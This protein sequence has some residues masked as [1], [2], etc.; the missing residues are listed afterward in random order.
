[1][2]LDKTLISPSR[3]RTITNT[4]HNRNHDSDNLRKMALIGAHVHGQH[5]HIETRIISNPSSLSDTAHNLRSSTPRSSNTYGQATQ[6]QQ[7]TDTLHSRI[8]SDSDSYS[9]NVSTDVSMD[10]GNYWSHDMKMEQIQNP[11][12][13]V[14]WKSPQAG[15]PALPVHKTSI[16]K[17]ALS[18]HSLHTYDQQAGFTEIGVSGSATSIQSPPLSSSQAQAPSPR[19]FGWQPRSTEDLNLITQLPSRDQPTRTV[20]PLI[21]PSLTPNELYQLQPSTTA[22]QPSGLGESTSIPICIQTPVPV[23]SILVGS[24]QTD[25]RNGSGSSRHV[26]LSSST[27]GTSSS[28]S[29]VNSAELAQPISQVQSSQSQLAPKASRAHLKPRTTQ[30]VLRPRFRRRNAQLGVDITT[31]GSKSSVQDGNCPEAD[32]RAQRK[33]LTDKVSSLATPAHLTPIPPNPHQFRYFLPAGQDQQQ[34]QYCQSQ[35][36]LDPGCPREPTVAGHQQSPLGPQQPDTFQVPQVAG[37]KRKATQNL[38]EDEDFGSGCGSGRETAI[39]FFTSQG[40]SVASPISISSRSASPEI[41]TSIEVSEKNFPLF[42][43]PS[44]PSTSVI[45]TAASTVSSIASSSTDATSIASFP[46][47]PTPSSILCSSFPATLPSSSELASVINSKTI[48]PHLLQ[49][50]GTSLGRKKPRL[51][52]PDIIESI[53]PAPTVQELMLEAQKRKEEKV[54]L[55]KSQLKELQGLDE[56][57]GS[58]EKLYE[59]LKDNGAK[60]NLLASLKETLNGIVDPRA[61]AAH[62]KLILAVLLAKP[63]PPPPSPLS[64]PWIPVFTESVLEFDIE[65]VP[66]TTSGSSS[67]LGRCPAAS[68]SSSVCLCT[69]TSSPA[70]APSISASNPPSA[71]TSSPTSCPIWKPVWVGGRRI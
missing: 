28:S 14:Q 66:T 2:A 1:M 4:I 49:Y 61:Q 33:Q 39:P 67:N 29:S 31:S 56:L 50:P 24:S 52:R 64:Q 27:L 59:I 7:A 5:P 45:S 18:S 32:H 35:Q 41:P 54:I 62:I 16:S 10:K 3:P 22:Q 20:T 36:H 44:S 17:P 47:S 65:H 11:S 60:Q 13:S 48:A 15:P 23:N 69:Q 43:S 42:C 8:C 55:Q 40:D 57:N 25:R 21:L 68:L 30:D 71:S 37:H 6:F 46:P 58:R 53:S 12:V 70:H 63:S 38:E 9:K 34:Q 26:S 51:D 19:V